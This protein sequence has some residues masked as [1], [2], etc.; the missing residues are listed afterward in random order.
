M[1]DLL[2]W[3]DSEFSGGDPFPDPL[4]ADPE[5]E[6]LVA[7]GGNLAPDLLRTAYRRG[8]FPWYNPGDEILWW[9]P[10]PRL[11]LFPD[12]VRVS[13]SLRQRLRSGRFTVTCD[14]DF[15]AVIAACAQ[16]R[17]DGLGTWLTPE[18]IAAYCRLHALGAAHSVEAWE[19]DTLAGGLYGVAIGR[20]FFGESMFHRRADASKVCLVTLC[21]WLREWNYELIDCQ[22]QT[23]HLERMGAEEVS[24]REF[25]R[26]L[27][28][29]RDAEPSPDAWRPGV[30]D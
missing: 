1:S 22:L 6:G 4:P 2:A 28:R 10:D 13:R 30:G 20:V 21:E 5:W 25:I 3:I 27:Q 18:M 17:R 26:L 29:W 24:R 11:V 8:I 23:P 12:R 15:A 9:S 7:M 19:G 16:P 14:R